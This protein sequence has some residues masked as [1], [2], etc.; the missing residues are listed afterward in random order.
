[1][2]GEENIPLVARPDEA[3]ADPVAIELFEPE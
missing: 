1:M 2:L 3:D